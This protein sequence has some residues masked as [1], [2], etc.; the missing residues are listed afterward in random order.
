MI[1]YQAVDVFTPTRPARSTF[2]ERESINEQLVAAI[3]TPG[4]QIVVYGYTGSGKTTL[5]EN[6]LYQLYETHLTSRC[7]TGLT[8][9][10]LVL[11]AFDQ[12]G[13][14]YGVETTQTKRRS[15]ATALK[16]EYLGI[17]AQVETELQTKRQLILPPQLTPQT[18]G[19]FLGEAKCCWVL[20]DFHKM[21]PAEKAKLAQV[22][23]VFMDM[24]DHYRELKIIAIGA[25]DTAREVVEY[26]AEM[27]NR[28]SEIHVPLMRDEEILQIPKIGQELLNFN[29][30]GNLEADLAKSSNGLASVCHQLC[31]NMCF[32]ADIDETLDTPI[33]LGR[34][35]FM[36]AVEQY[37]AEASDTLK[38]AF[39]RAFK[40]DRK[41]KYDDSKLIVEA[42]LQVDQDGANK[43]IVLQKI[44]DVQP[45]YP[46]QRLTISLQQLQK[47]ERGMLLRHDSSSGRYSFKD[48]FYRAFALAHAQREQTD[49]DSQQ[50]ERF[51][52]SEFEKMI[53]K[54][55][56]T[57]Q[58]LQ[59]PNA[60]EQRN[61]MPKMDWNS[62]MFTRK[63]RFR[64][65]KH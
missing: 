52:R 44:R 61:Q 35:T 63:R 47:E 23:K 7:V 18:L 56:L 57:R 10:Q 1:K 43:T 6:K 12:L 32:A 58:T 34:Q 24:S 30:S 21:L 37:L 17:K 54:L 4:K 59:H 28:V 62:P 27:R 5:L 29:M 49:N 11:D 40:N 9:E 53:S 65:Q 42:L 26:D 25:V 36:K 31:L 64:K 14:F 38:S 46:T 3:R 13:G 55:F 22:M 19:R 39:D 2:V 8:L 16:T 33:S 41:L 60:R 51:V 50:Q 20:E 48:P 45:E 15:R